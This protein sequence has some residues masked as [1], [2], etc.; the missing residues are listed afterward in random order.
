MVKCIIFDFDGTL[1]DSKDVFI[2]VYNQI[3][4]KNKYRAIEPDT[5]AYLQTLTINERCRYL[6]VPVYRIPFLAVEFLNLYKNA[7]QHVKLFEGIREMLQSL[8][9]EG[10]ETAI[11][12]SNVKSNIELF[13]KANEIGSITRIYCSRSLFGKDKLIKAF[14]KKYGMTADQILYVGDELRDIVAC[15]KAGV[16]VAWVE[17]GYDIRQAVIDADPDYLLSKPADILSILN[18]EINSQSQLN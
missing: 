14:L 15:K 1:A 13:L 9:R 3:A 2:S 10:F 12:S 6:K 8:H 5:L 17:W 7:L 16:R 4:A 18:A 11:I